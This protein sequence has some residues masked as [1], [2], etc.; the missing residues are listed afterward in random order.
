MNEDIEKNKAFA[1]HLLKRM[2]NNND[3]NATNILLIR[4]IKRLTQRC[5]LF[6]TFV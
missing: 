4:I 1:W 3:R 6:N 2:I 5:C